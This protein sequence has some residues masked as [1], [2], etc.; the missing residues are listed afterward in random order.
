REKNQKNDEADVERD[1]KRSGNNIFFRVALFFRFDEQVC[2]AG[3]EN[4]RLDE[5]SQFR[6]HLWRLVEFV[7][8]ALL[9]WFYIG[10]HHHTGIQ[11]IERRIFGDGA[12]AFERFGR[13]RTGNQRAVNQNAKREMRR[14]RRLSV[15]RGR[16]IGQLGWQNRAVIHVSG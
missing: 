9:G 3:I 12:E 15:E 7:Y 1:R 11:N 13:H 8:L 10:R 16:A 6:R 4:I 14:D 5:F 2:F